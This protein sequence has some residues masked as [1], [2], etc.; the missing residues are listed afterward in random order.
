MAGSWEK[1]LT[2]RGTQA[3][4][5]SSGY[6]SSTPARVSS[7]TAPSLTPGQTT[8]WPWTSMPAVEQGLQ[9]A[10]AGRPP[11]VAQQVGPG[12]SGS[13]AWMDTNSGLS[14]SVRTRSR[15]I[16]VK[17]VSVVKLP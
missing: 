2:P 3:T 8:I 6:R 12:R 15:S 1:R 17:R 5:A 10:Q 14:R 4:V 7:R 16:S 9:P 13:V 11:P